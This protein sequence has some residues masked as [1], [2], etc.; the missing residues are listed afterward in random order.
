LYCPRKYNHFQFTPKYSLLSKNVTFSIHAGAI[1]LWDGYYIR[2]A[3]F[4]YTYDVG[5][6]QHGLAG[7]GVSFSGAR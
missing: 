2:K 5:V 4:N 1:F 7:E 6:V 3:I